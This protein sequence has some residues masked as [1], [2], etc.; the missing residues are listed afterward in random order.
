MTQARWSMGAAMGRPPAEGSE[1]SP[2]RERPAAQ[3]QPSSPRPYRRRH[4]RVVAALALVALGPLALLT[5]SSIRLGGDAVH[6]QVQARVTDA[7]TTSAELVGQQMQD[8]ASLVQSDA[9]RAHLATALAP[10]PAHRRRPHVHRLRPCRACNRAAT[11][12]AVAFVAD[13]QGRLID[14]LPATPSIVGQ[15]FATATGTEGSWRVGDDPTSPRPTRRRP[16]VKPESSPRLIKLSDLLKMAGPVPSSASW[17][18]PT[19]LGTIQHF[20]DGFAAAD[21]V[22]LTVTDQQGTVIAAPG[23]GTNP[24]SARLAEVQPG[25]GRRARRTVGHAVDR[26]RNSPGSEC[27]HPGAGSGLDGPGRGA[28]PGCVRIIESPASHRRS[29]RRAAGAYSGGGSRAPRSQPAATRAGR[30]T[31]PGIRDVPGF[32]HREHPP[33]GLHQRRRRAAVRAA[34]PGSRGSPGVSP[35][36][37]A[38]QER[39]R[40]LPAR[41][42]RLVH[43]PPTGR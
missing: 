26:K 7:A 19:T 13:T 37:T 6:S 30:A 40:L 28:D 12:I 2:A 5:Y 11:G 32:G 39:L 15:N 33:H 43:R 8:L 22:R 38:D 25:G 14:I 20:V 23:A 42:G 21:A 29:H 41:S 4:L 36:R 17:W 31:S 24:T 9:G 3:A 18:P 34:Q 16:R 1:P 27:L 10:R 35:R